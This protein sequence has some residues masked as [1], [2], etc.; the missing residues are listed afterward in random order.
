MSSLMGL[1]LIRDLESRLDV[2]TGH[3]LSVHTWS[4]PRQTISFA[5]ILLEAYIGPYYSD[6]AFNQFLFDCRT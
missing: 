1:Q 4:V 6:V 3:E 5:K 2:M